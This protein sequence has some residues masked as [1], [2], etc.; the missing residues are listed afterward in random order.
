MT[1]DQDPFFIGWGETPS[2]D[3]RF[4]L[5]A[6]PVGLAGVAG[7]S[8]AV[9]NTLS[10]PGAGSWQTGKI[11]TI[12]GL[13]Q[14]L[15]YPHLLVPVADKDF[16]MKT[17]LLV[18]QGKCISALDLEN[19]KGAAVEAKGVLIE[20]G[21]RQMLEVPPLLN[22]WYTP[23]AEN[24]GL[25]PTPKTEKIASGITLKGQILDTKCFLGVMR[26]STGRTHKACASLCIRGGIPPSFRVMTKT[27]R[28][29]IL[30]LTDQNGGPASMDIL[31]FVADPVAMTG[32]VFQVGDLL[33]FRAASKTLTRLNSTM[34]LWGN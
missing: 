27:G 13:F 22:K 12:R 29:K 28:E 24:F 23:T 6:V 19:I 18:A 21:T 32:D 5:G 31:P 30:L 7:L 1:K 2:V 9:A 3:R 16:A 25:Y 17:V 33:Q 20:R 26:P 34:E 11:H 15:P 8:W 10:D 14:K 4:L